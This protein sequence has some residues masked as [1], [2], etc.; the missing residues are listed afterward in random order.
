MSINKQREKENFWSLE[1]QKPSN[2][3][4]RGNTCEDQSR[5]KVRNERFSKQRHETTCKFSRSFLFT[6]L[7]KKK[8]RNSNKYL[9]SYYYYYYLANLCSLGRE[10]QLHWY[11][12]YLHTKSNNF[13]HGR[14][15]A[16]SISSPRLPNLPWSFP[17]FPV[18]KITSDADE[19]KQARVRALTRIK[20]ETKGGK[21]PVG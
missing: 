10:K 7:K 13:V 5:Q 3:K 15:A 11:L 9:F 4:Q 2:G 19:C 14:V 12:V 20:L 16:I 6:R 21:K 1:A 17:R 18:A 8:K